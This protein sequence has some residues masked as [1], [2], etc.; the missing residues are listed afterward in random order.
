M[1]CYIFYDQDHKLL[2]DADIK[3]KTK[4]ANV[5]A[6]PNLKITIFDITVIYVKPCPSAMDGGHITRAHYLIH[7]N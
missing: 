1:P 4:L 5:F 6:N 7:R 3:L 2:T